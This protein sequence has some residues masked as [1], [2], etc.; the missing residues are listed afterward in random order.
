MIN[1]MAVIV[2]TVLMMGSSPAA[3][4]AAPDDETDWTTDMISPP[5]APGHPAPAP[6]TPEGGFSDSERIRFSEGMRE[7]VLDQIC[8]KAEIPL[9]HT[10]PLTN[11]GGVGVEG[12]R[13]L[14][15]L[16]DNRVAIQDS[17]KVFLDLG[18][19]LVTEQ[20]GK[21]TVG[22]SV[23]GH[24]DGTSFVLRPMQTTN[25]C[26]EIW[27]LLK[28]TQSKSII[29]FKA[30]RLA[31]MGV[32]ELWKLPAVLTIGH[33][34]SATRTLRAADPSGI[35]ET[36][37]ISFG[38][39]QTGASI[40]SVYRMSEDKMRFRL[41]I[42]HARI[43]NKGGSILAVH[44]AIH[45]FSAPAGIL[46]KVVDSQTTRLLSHYLTENIGIFFASTDGQQLMMEFILDPRNPEDMDELASVL[47]GDFVTLLKMAKRMVTLQAN[48][49]RARKDFGELEKEHEARF[50]RPANF[51]GLDIYHAQ[52]RNLHLMLPFLFDHVRASTLADDRIVRL[53]AQGGEVHIYRSDRNVNSGMIDVPIKG[54]LVKHNSQQSAQSF[55]FKD[56]DGKTTEP[57][58]VYIRQGG[59]LRMASDEV[60]GI[61]VDVNEILG[62]VGARGGEPNPRT[63]L[64]LDR[65]L[66]PEPEVSVRQVHGQETRISPTYHDG[67]LTFTLVLNEKAVAAIID[68][69]GELVARSFANTLIDRWDRKAVGWILDNGGLQADGRL[70][71]DGAA[72]K[73][74]FSTDDHG[75]QWLR[76]QC[77]KA[78]EIIKDIAAVREAATP[79]AR[80][81]AMVRLMSGR[82]E[83]D[84]AYG[85]MMKVLVQLVD[86][87]DVTADL[88]FNVNKEIKGD[89]NLHAHML[90]KRNRPENDGLKRA[91]EAKN[92]F[93][94]PSE[95]VD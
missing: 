80:S 71:V 24:F 79:E 43:H 20:I 23:G 12:V 32:G 17:Q 41:R 19:N 37:T 60:R 70:A 33:S 66:P 69:S 92:R 3:A 51:P 49:D 31:E 28:V 16:P 68:A 73:K 61:A 25:S 45:I 10:F 22:I 55:A 21:E 75:V 91:G 1:P 29:P 39:G 13:R 74:E 46:I 95:L 6:T 93:A 90:L 53:D 56:K 62:M 65:M 64:P 85:E 77:E 42:S 44:P 89:P 88:V 15:V 94:Q 72:V 9:G 27:D 11:F 67:S 57:Q 18:H 7:H 52:S 2:A 59:F 38:I 82:G 5:P 36:T 50:K 30:Q 87:R 83:S 81:E 48:A 78:S 4:A 76:A 26:A 34:E 14:R 40:M 63:K 86:P 84:L 35:T 58:A 47:R 8:R 54:Q